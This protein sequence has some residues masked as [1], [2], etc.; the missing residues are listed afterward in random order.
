MGG[1]RRMNVLDP[2][3]AEDAE[4]GR[5]GLRRNI[6]I[7]PKPGTVEIELE[8]DFHHFILKLEH[9][10]TTVTTVQTAAPRHPWTTCPASGPFLASRLENT[11]LRDVRGF[12]TPLIHCTHLHD[13]AV[14][15]ARHALSGEA[16]FYSAFVADPVEGK[17]FASLHRNGVCVLEWRLNGQ[18]IEPG[19][20]YA[21]YNLRKLKVW[22]STLDP[23]PRE[24]AEILR[25]AVFVANGRG[26]SPG[27]VERASEL[28]GMQ[29]AC[30][31]F[32][33]DRSAHAAPVVGSK[34]DYS[35][36]KT[37]PLGSRLQTL[38]QCHKTL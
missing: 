34:K 5:P 30:F 4:S 3:W 2:Q 16:L 1:S 15:A 22:A 9:D 21:G 37:M 13:L 38:A 28:E 20:A 10:G 8:D 19:S 25:R 6:L 17:V 35:S 33:T 29:G 14:I 24:H 12:D 36:G 11:P 27:S 18:D 26:F 31:T 32:D 23:E 7:L